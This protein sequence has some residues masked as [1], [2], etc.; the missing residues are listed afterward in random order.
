MGR[1]R[2]WLGGLGNLAGSGLGILRHG[3]QCLLRG[4]GFGKRGKKERQ[5]DEGDQA[6]LMRVPG[7]T[8]IGLGFHVLL[9]EPDGP[10]GDE[11]AFRTAGGI[12]FDLRRKYG[13][14]V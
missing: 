1:R 3:R 12:F 6:G 8:H 9:S 14:P 2:F 5:G 10:P 11:L 4:D 13:R 7:K